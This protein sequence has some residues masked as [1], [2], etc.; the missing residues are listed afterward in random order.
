MKFTLESFDPLRLLINIYLVGVLCQGH[1][2]KVFV[3]L[4]MFD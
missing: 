1:Q 4:G 2:L 3:L